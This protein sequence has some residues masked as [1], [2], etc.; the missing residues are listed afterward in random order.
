MSN[1]K[2]TKNAQSEGKETTELLTSTIQQILGGTHV[3]N[4]N[5]RKI[6]LSDLSKDNE[7][8]GIYF[9]AH[10]CGPCRKFTPELKERYSNWVEKKKALKLVLV[11]LDKE[12]ESFDE[13]YG[14][15]HT[16]WFA[17]SFNETERRKD[18]NARLNLNQSIPC[19]IFVDSKTGEV[20][21]RNGRTIVQN[22]VN[23]IDFPWK[24]YKVP[25]KPPNIWSRVLVRLLIFV[26]VMVFVKFYKS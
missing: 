8:I 13:Y 19:L 15:M 17:I 18:V 6:A 5:G 3:I 25:Y 10:W 26:G 22:D 14:S 9:S 11:S 12:R 2:K 20:F 7:V 24:N 1:K 23:G 21:A 16:D 4:Q